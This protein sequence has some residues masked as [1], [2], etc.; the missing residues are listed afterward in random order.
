M[1]AEKPTLMIRAPQA[2][3]YERMADLAGQL[4]YASEADAVAKRLGGM[5]SSKD[6]AVFV[7]ELPSGE[8]TGWIGVFLYR[9]IEA[10]ARAEISGLVVDGRVR[11]QGI[12]RQLLERAEEWARDKGCAAI[13]LRSN[14][15]RDRAHAFY[16]R[17]G[18]RHIK[19]QKTFRKDL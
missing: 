6:H 11:S 15:I 9:C 16:Q 8:I 14:V 12:G 19:T 13:G 1:A 3:D 17:L 4:G 5:E 7:A 2:R 10:D 18:Y